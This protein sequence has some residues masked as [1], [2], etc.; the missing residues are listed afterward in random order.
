RRRAGLPRDA[1]LVPGS[2][3]LVL[4]T[5]YLLQSLILQPLG[6]ELERLAR[7]PLAVHQPRVLDGDQDL[8]NDRRQ[9]LVKF[10]EIAGNHPDD[11]LGVELHPLL[12]AELQ[13][14]RL[15][16]GLAD[17]LDAEEVQVLG[18]ERRLG[19]RERLS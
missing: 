7:V 18:Q 17:P 14:V 12:E 19:D 11:E 15:P 8:P 10:V 2:W 3:Y 9:P 5:W 4:G 6:P 16:C 1:F 13:V